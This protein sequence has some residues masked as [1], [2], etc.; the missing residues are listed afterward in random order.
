MKQVTKEIVGCDD[1]ELGIKREAPLKYI[2][3]YPKNIVPKAIVFIIPG[4]GED[5]N[6][7]Y[8]EHVSKYVAEKFSVAVVNVFYHC[9]YS[10]ESNGATLEFDDFD[11]DVLKKVIHKYDINFSSAKEITKESVIKI[12]TAADKEMSI[13]MTLVPF[14]SEYQ[15][16]GVMQALDH[17]YVLEDI[18]KMSGLEDVDKVICIGSSHG[19]YI[20]NMIAKLNPRVVDYVIDNSSYTKAPLNYVVGKDNNVNFPEFTLGNKKLK[21][22]C[23]V[24]TYWTTK[25]SSK[26]YFSEDRKSIRNLNNTEHIKTMAQ[27][28]NSK[29]K[30]I[31]YHSLEDALAPVADK[32]AYSK[33]LESYGFES[34][35]KIVSKQKDIDG[36]FIKN[37][38]HGMGMSIKELINIELP[39]ILKEFVEQKDNPNIQNLTTY[40]CNNITYVFNLS[41]SKCINNE[42]KYEIN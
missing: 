20:A 2:L 13:S 40:K 11:I 32:I 22:N 5:T 10:R 37:L 16:F 36:K 1:F 27:N 12:L 28:A 26:Y 23:F 21:I 14:N 18:K 34:T 30:Y 8:M 17:L 24:Q 38:Q 19:G 6:S 39:L 9:F 29:T 15:N 7:G 33:T 42:K 3:T 41:E 35:L 25:E 4:F 31:F